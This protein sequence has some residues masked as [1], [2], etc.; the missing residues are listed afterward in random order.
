MHV[1]VSLCMVT[2]SN[3]SVYCCEC[4]C[5]V[6][7]FVLFCF[8]V[9]SCECISLCVLCCLMFIDM[10]HIQMQL[11]QSLDQW[12]EHVYMCVCVFLINYIQHAPLHSNTTCFRVGYTQYCYMYLQLMYSFFLVSI[13]TR[14]GCVYV[15]M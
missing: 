11:M 8:T 15:C 9:L 13:D 5:F 14:Y 12:N 7:V 2:W 3:T 6:F 10:F 1:T 4:V